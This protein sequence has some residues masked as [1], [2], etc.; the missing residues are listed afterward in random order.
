MKTLNYVISGLFTLAIL[1]TAAISHADLRLKKPVLLKA[2]LVITTTTLHPVKYG[3]IK[4]GSTVNLGFTVKNKGLVSTGPSASYTL[5]CTVLSGGPTCPVPNTTR[6]L[7]AI[8]AGASHTVNLYGFI[9][10]KVG[11]YRVYI[12]VKPTKSRGR[13]R[14]VDINVGYALRKRPGRT[15]YSR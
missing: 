15:K 14:S 8:A 2:N 5:S 7:P 12:R 4:P 3:K 6:P 11:K 9:P 10:A 13:P 1:T